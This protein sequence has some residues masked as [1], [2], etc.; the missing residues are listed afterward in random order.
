MSIIS[1]LVDNKI[2]KGGEDKEYKCKIRVENEDKNESDMYSVE[3]GVFRPEEMIDDHAKSLAEKID[4]EIM[5][6]LTR[7]DW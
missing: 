6:D 3:E 1:R 2:K 4:K 7:G 5:E